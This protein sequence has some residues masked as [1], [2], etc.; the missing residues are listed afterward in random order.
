MA[1]R[2]GFEPSSHSRGLVGALRK[3][4]GVLVT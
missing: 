2:T 3:E 4:A 1:V